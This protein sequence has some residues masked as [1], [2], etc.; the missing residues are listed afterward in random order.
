[1]STNSFILAILTINKF[2]LFI[3]LTFFAFKNVTAHQHDLPFSKK[4]IPVTQLNAVVANHKKY[5]LKKIVFSVC[6]CK[7][8]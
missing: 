1:M 3:Y 7:E 5:S 2:F 6:C 8:K 4:I